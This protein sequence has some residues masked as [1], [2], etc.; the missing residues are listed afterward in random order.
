MTA[1]DKKLLDKVMEVAGANENR[2]HDG[3]VVTLRGTH[4]RARRSYLWRKL[5]KAAIAKIR[6]RARTRAAA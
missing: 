4:D 5:E 6:R 2:I 1:D 3:I